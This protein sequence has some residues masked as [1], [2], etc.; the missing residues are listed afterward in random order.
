MTVHKPTEER[1]RQ[2]ADA[3]LK[4][5]AEQGLG[6]FTTAAIAAEVGI[7][8]GT[9]FRHFKN[10]EEIVLAAM[11]RVE[12]MIFEGFPPEDPDP[13]RRVRTFFSQRATLYE[14]HPQ[15]ATIVHSEDLVH[16]AGAL[17]AQRVATWK[18][19]LMDFVIACA[20]EA[21]A[22]GQIPEWL[23]PRN[24]AVIWFGTHIALTRFQASSEAAVTREQVWS[25]LERLIRR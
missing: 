10:K 12:E 8:D 15:I 11:D 23:P 19:R 16:A 1:Q 4:V 6:R 14:A 2:I 9:L 13:M 21:S 17:G 18:K 24:L 3:A 20:E 25:N 22:N 7:T 5:I